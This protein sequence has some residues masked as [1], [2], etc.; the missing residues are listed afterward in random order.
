M[1]MFSLSTAVPNCPGAKSSE[2]ANRKLTDVNRWHEK[3]DPRS[4]M[5]LS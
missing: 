3:V 1:K 2:R 5:A 4:R